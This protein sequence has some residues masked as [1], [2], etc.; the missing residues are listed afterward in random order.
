MSDEFFWG[1]NRNGIYHK[2]EEITGRRAKALGKGIA[3]EQSGL[4]WKGRRRSPRIAAL[5]RTTSQAYIA[6]YLR[7]QAEKVER[8]EPLPVEPEFWP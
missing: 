7:E 5:E 8:S 4:D 6:K 3:R 2:H 1:P